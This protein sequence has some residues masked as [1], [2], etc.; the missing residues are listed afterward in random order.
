MRHELAAMR[1]KCT[2]QQYPSKKDEHVEVFL[3]DGAYSGCP[4]ENILASAAVLTFPPGLEH[5]SRIAL[6]DQDSNAEKT[7][8]K[9]ENA[10]EHVG[11]F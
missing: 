3:D 9:G 11:V 4:E 6:S 7:A 2:Y 8:A 1:I 5:P 10:E